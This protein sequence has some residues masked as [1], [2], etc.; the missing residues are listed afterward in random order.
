VNAGLGRL[1]L[2]AD[3]LAKGK[4]LARLGHGVLRVLRVG[5][6]LT[7]RIIPVKRRSAA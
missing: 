5:R 2:L 7:Q 6:N 3:H 1:D 4:S